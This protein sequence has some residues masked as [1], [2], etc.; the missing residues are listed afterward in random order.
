MQNSIILQPKYIL[1]PSL[2]IPYEEGKQTDKEKKLFCHMID[3]FYYFY[4]PTSPA[5]V[6]VHDRQTPVNTIMVEL[7]YIQHP[8]LLG[9]VGRNLQEGIFRV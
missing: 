6:K 5:Y 8:H 9:M 2:N 7:T 1:R 3:H 4:N